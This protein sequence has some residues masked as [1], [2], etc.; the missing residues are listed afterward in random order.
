MAVTTTTFDSLLSGLSSEA[1]N[2]VEIIMR[3]TSTGVSK[4][5]SFATFAALLYAW[6]T[7]NKASDLASVLGGW[8]YGSGNNTDANEFPDRSVYVWATASYTE[9]N[10]PFYGGVM[11]T[12]FTGDY[13][14][15]FAFRDSP[16]TTN[17]QFAYRTFW[18]GSWRSWRITFAN[19]EIFG[20]I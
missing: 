10:K 6:I 9:Q 4:K 2:S 16:T 14:V 20:S 5:M 7:S 11:I 19:D 12:V 18:G 15:Q 3:N 1:T 17:S 8:V 13:G